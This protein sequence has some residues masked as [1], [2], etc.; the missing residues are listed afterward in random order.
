MIRSRLGRAALVVSG[1]ILL[2]RLLGFGRNVLLYALLGREVATDLYVDAFT[3]PDYLF[4]LMAGGYLSITL[5]PILSRHHAAGDDD[6]A[7]RSFTAVFRMVTTALV[8]LTVVLVVFARPLVETVF[9]RI[10]DSAR[11]T[12][13]TRVAL[14]SQVFFGMGTLL[15]AAQYA[16]QRFLIPTLAPLVYNLGII[17]GGAAE[18]DPQVVDEGSQGGDEEPLPCVLGGHQQRAHAEEHLGDEGDPGE[19][20]EPGRILDP[21]EHRLDEGTGEHDQDD[22]EGHEGRGHHPEHRREG[23]AGGVVVPGGVVAGEDRDEGDGEVA[24][25]HQEEQV[26]GD[27]EGVHVQVGG[28]LPT[29]QGVEQHVAAEAEQPGQQDASGDDQRGPAEAASDHAR[30]ARA[31]RTS[32]GTWRSPRPTPKAMS[33]L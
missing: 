23:T 9:P 21:G 20:G 3:I 1:G 22:G 33:G 8:A 12:D 28:D 27:G 16:R 32:S 30:A 31:P 6:A 14:V 7:R 29:Q 15:M 18:D 26:V 17:L 4:F 10:E 25:G 11:L 24:P 13:L 5:V 19:V 2:S